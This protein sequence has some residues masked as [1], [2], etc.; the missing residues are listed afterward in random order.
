MILSETIDSV[1]D[2]EAFNTELEAEKLDATYLQ[3]V[4]EQIYENALE[5]IGDDE[6]TQLDTEYD[7]NIPF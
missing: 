7:D 1:I 4:R 6:S 5:L 2:V 3:A